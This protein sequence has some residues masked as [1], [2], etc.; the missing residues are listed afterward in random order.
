MTAPPR[1][2]AVIAGGGPVGMVLALELGR[3]GVR[4]VLLN[5]RVGPTEWP[6]A[7][8]TSPRSM[9]HLRRLGVARRFRELGLAPD[10]PSDVTYFTRLAGYELAR[11]PMP[12]WGAAVAET[13]RGA[14]PWAGPEPAH[15]G[16]QLFL[17]QAV[18]E[19]LADFP[20]IER[21]FGWRCEGFEDRG[22]HVRVRAVEA[23]SGRAETIEA[24]YLAGCD[25]GG[26]IVRKGLG[27]EFEGDAGVVRPFMGGSMVSAFVRMAPPPGARWPK[28]SWQYWVVNAE[29]RAVCIAVDGHERY[30]WGIQL[31]ERRPLDAGY[32]RGLVES[33]TGVPALKEL[34]SFVPWT[35]GYRLLAQ[36]YGAGR[37]LLAGDAAHLFT[38]TGGMGMN[39]GIDDAVNL[40]WKLAAMAKGWG[41]PRLLASYEADRRPIGAR[42]LAWSKRFA[43]SVGT[44]P[45]T[46]AIET[47]TAEGARER[48]AVGAR[49][50]A[51]AAHEFLIPGIHLGFRY[52]NSPLIWPDGT[53]APPDPANDYAPT[54]RP[55]HRAP[56][57]WL[58]P[59]VALYDRLG[60]EFTLLQLGG[61]SAA[62][63][64]LRPAFAAR[65]IPLDVLT[66]DDAALN[67]DARAL[68]GR[69]NALIG[70]DQIVYWRGDTGPADPLALADRVRGA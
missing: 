55:G 47:D 53:P 51:H 36:R 17:E 2:F 1:P 39:T 37:V 26:S 21:R 7:N 64:A 24:A 20:A 18:F 27:I 62:A 49:L 29:V 56:H 42:N 22:D 23:A 41:G 14:G 12:G 11:L 66:L 32:V 44:T 45:A 15:R 65:G 30:V 3:R 58:A 57:V 19:R 9:E 16:S 50:A 48:A 35:A 54:A 69:G 52:E 46:P 70:P 6:K 38:P 10:Y 33:A 5:D 59:G 4:C 61:N 60:R 8:A 43:D 28:R 40:A 25:G 31:P 13:A 34:I 63:Q 68:Y 67:A